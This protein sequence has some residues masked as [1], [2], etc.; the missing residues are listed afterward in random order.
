[1]TRPAVIQRD[2]GWR[3]IRRNVDDLGKFEVR[4][5]VQG[6]AGAYDDKTTLVEVATWNEFGTER[7]PSRPFMRKTA[8]ENRRRVGILGEGFL[9]KIIDGSVTT[10]GAL[11]QIGLWF[12]AQVVKTINTSKGWAKPNAQS[13]IDA[14]GSS[15]PLVDTSHLRKNIKHIVRRKGV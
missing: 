9:K 7:A 1:M 4:V 8:D 6:D 14:K 12:A 3:R 11:N 10:Q 13:T 5:G 2:L 15:H